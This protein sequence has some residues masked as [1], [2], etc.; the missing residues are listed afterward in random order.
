MI[1]R[2]KVSRRIPINKEQGQKLAVEL[3]VSI[4]V[5][6]RSSGSNA[7]KTASSLAEITTQAHF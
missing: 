2:L 5:N 3:F 6:F 4:A 7:L 1:E